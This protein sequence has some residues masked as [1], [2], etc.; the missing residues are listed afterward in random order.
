MEDEEAATKVLKKG[1]DPKVWT[2]KFACTGRGGSGKGCGALLQVGK[3]DLFVVREQTW[4]SYE[5][6]YGTKSAVRFRCPECGV[7]TAVMSEVPFR[8]SEL[9]KRSAWLAKGGGYE[10]R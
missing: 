6:E 10:G 3:E 4:Y 9:P 2:R 8:F 5:E 7:E 1:R